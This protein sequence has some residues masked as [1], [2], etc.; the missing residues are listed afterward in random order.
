MRA[1]AVCSG[2]A[3]ALVTAASL[4]AAQAPA[5]PAAQPPA[6]PGRWGLTIGYP[7][8]FGVIYQPT[9]RLALRPDMTF[10]YT[11]SRADSETNSSHQWRVGSGISAL[12]YLQPER[13]LRVY[14]SPSYSYRRL[15]QTTTQT[16]SVT[17]FANGVFSITPRTVETSARNNQHGVAGVVGVEVRVHDGLGF[18]AEGGVQYRR[19]RLTADGPTGLTLGNTTGDVTSVGGVGVAVYF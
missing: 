3:L 1:F 15:T 5:P 6:D 10:G 9:R 8:S 2:A 17:S 11:G 13:P 18:F 16:T 4:A 7:G 12:I 19:L 14:V